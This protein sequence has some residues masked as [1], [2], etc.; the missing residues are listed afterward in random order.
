MSHCVADSNS[1][2]PILCGPGAS[3]IPVIE[4]KCVTELPVGTIYILNYG[5]I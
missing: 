1:A 4:Y 5:Y 3:T 2:P